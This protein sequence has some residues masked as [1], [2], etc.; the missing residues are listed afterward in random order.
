MI[1][2]RVFG[3][4]EDFLVEDQVGRL[5]GLL[6][7]EVGETAMIDVL[8]HEALAVAVDDDALDELRGWID[9]GRWDYPV[10]RDR[11][12][13][14]RHAEA[15][16]GA[17]VARNRQR[18]AGLAQ[19]RQVFLQQRFAQVV[20]AAG[21]DHAAPGLH[22]ERAGRL[23]DLDT[24]H[25]P[26][27]AFHQ[28]DHGTVVE[29]GNALI[30]APL[31][32]RLHARCP[33]ILAGA[34]NLVSA[35]SRSRRFAIGPGLFVARPH[36][37]G[38]IHQEHRLA[39]EVAAFERHALRFQPVEMRLAVPAERKRCIGI[40]RVAAGHEER[41][42]LLGVVLVASRFLYR[43][44]A[45][46]IVDAGRHGAC[47]AAARSALDDQHVRARTVRLE[48][49]ASAGDALPGDD[50]IDLARPLGD[51]GRGNNFGYLGGTHP[52][53]PSISAATAASISLFIGLRRSVSPPF[54]CRFSPVMKHSS[55]ARKTAA[56]AM[57]SEVPM[58]PSG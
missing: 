56:A 49:G 13:A 50:D 45:A 29:R 17:V 3:V 7:H 15:H 1:A 6:H 46:Q 48:R 54:T 8:G 55:L 5:P 33:R 38:G 2:E 58:R 22:E 25:A 27:G 12:G 52:V 19:Q 36:Q 51:I 11:M 31:N 34:R 42:H 26:L 53:Q 20:A 21:D 4:G 39:A 41:G 9:R 16:A 24:H 57:S 14:R 40:E 43:C 32:E 18:L 28:G 35:R 30:L 44:A 23:L 37:A 47:P 10:H